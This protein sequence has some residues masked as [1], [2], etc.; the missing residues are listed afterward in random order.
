MKTQRKL[1]TIYKPLAQP[2]FLGRGHMAT[3]VI[4]VPFEESD[5]FILLMD[6]VLNKEDEEPAGG[7][8]PHA[9][10]E[11]VTLILEGILKDGKHIMKAG[12]F[13]LMTAGKG[14]VHSET[15]DKPGHMRILQ[16]WLNLPKKDRNATPRVQYLFSEHVPVLNENGMQLRLYSGNFAGLHASLENHVPLIVAEIKLEPGVTTAQLLPGNFNAFLYV[17]EGKVQAGHNG[18]T[19]QKGQVGWLDVLEEDD[20]SVLSLQAGDSGAHF[21]LYAALPQKEP[22]ISHGPFI[23]DNREDIQ[24]L[25]R[26]FRQGKMPHIH[27][28][29]EEQQLVW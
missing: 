14:V 7:P 2:G 22:I 17:L 11:T 29:P 8:H 4:Q 6:D 21:V 18:S 9:G 25:Y 12:D 20:E 16:L 23:A 27:T 24:R 15:I 10:F 1:A 26:E 13:Q 19:L 28:V 5:P 3:P